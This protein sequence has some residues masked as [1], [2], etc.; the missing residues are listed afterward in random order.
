MKLE[1]ISDNA[2]TAY[3]SKDEMAKLGITKDNAKDAADIIIGAAAVQL[4]CSFDFG[5]Y[6][7][8]SDAAFAVTVRAKKKNAPL[9]TAILCFDDGGALYRACVFL[10]G[11]NV[12]SSRLLREGTGKDL[13][14]YL[15]IEYQ[16]TGDPLWLSSVSELADRSY[17]EKNAFFYYICEHCETVFEKNALNLIANS[18]KTW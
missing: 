12:R 11:K 9:N 7:V 16:G 6:D 18:D 8:T 5:E 13:T 1:K 17:H 4:G 15:L 10:R 14:Y 2:V 3:I